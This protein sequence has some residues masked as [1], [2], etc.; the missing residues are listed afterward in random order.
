MSS[1]TSTVHLVWITA[2]VILIALAG[3]WLLKIGRWPRRRGSERHCRRC[4]YNL[5]GLSSAQCPECGA[6][7]LERNVVIGERRRRTGLAWSGVLLLIA[8]LVGSG[9]VWWGPLRGVD[10]YRYKPSRWVAADL[11]SSDEEVAARAWRELERRRDEG[12]LSDT[13]EYA[14]A[15]AALAEQAKPQGRHG[16]L[17]EELVNYLTRRAA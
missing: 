10:W 14:A 3:I 13:V 15:E 4:D 5:S 17:E 7:L 9:M 11:R 12:P 6:E 1:V 16:P 8:S 2:I